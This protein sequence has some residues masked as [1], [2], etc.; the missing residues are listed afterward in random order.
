MGRT[1]E[2]SGHVLAEAEIFRDYEN[3][4][5]DDREAARIFMATLA[6][7]NKDK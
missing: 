2:I 1:D 4:T 3:L 7:R 6:K 5:E